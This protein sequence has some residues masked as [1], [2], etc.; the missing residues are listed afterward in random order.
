MYRE[1]MYPLR[2]LRHLLGHSPD[3]ASPDIPRF[4]SERFTRRFR[5]EKEKWREKELCS[6][7][8]GIDRFQKKGRNANCPSLGGG[9]WR[10]EVKSRLG[11]QSKVKKN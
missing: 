6:L 5:G 4:M 3:V 8:G 10:R 11:G 2:R 7:S 9:N 1:P